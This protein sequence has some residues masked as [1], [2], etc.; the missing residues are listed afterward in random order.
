MEHRA[1][2]D[3]IRGKNHNRNGGKKV[4]SPSGAAAEIAHSRLPSGGIQSRGSTHSQGRRNDPRLQGQSVRI[5]L[6]SEGQ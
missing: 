4:D 2:L 5:R 3:S 6:D 1:A